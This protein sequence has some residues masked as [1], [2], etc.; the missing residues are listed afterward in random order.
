MYPVIFQTRGEIIITF[1]IR[2]GSELDP[3]NLPA[4]PGTELK[5]PDHERFGLEF[6]PVRFKEGNKS[7]LADID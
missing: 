4:D 7:R 5:I 2:R 1:E 6:I 3:F